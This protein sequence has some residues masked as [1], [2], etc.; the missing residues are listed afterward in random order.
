MDYTPNSYRRKA[1]AKVA[2]PIYN[3]KK[4]IETMKAVF[5]T[6]NWIRR[7]IE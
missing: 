7:S 1:S 6:L 3:L 5:S 4:K 2:E